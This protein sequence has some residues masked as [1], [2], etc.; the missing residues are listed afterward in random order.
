MWEITHQ[1]LRQ[2][3]EQI[4]ERK[5]PATVIHAREIVMM[6]FRHAIERGHNYENPALLVRPSSIAVFPPKDR[7]HKIKYTLPRPAPSSLS[8]SANNVRI[9]PI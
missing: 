5:A 8:I 3:C 2:L 7:L 1:D 4:V 6:V 9:K